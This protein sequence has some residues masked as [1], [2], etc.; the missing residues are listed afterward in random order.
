MGGKYV[1]LES[2][3]FLTWVSVG[4]SIQESCIGQGQLLGLATPRSIGNVARFGARVSWELILLK[5]Q[6]VKW[7]TGEVIGVAAIIWPLFIANR[8]KAAGGFSF[9]L[10]GGST[11]PE[12]LRG[13]A[14]FA[15]ACISFFPLFRFKTDVAVVRIRRADFAQTERRANG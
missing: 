14:C 4:T 9:D 3:I 13:L 8:V 1:I 10:T 7:I 15:C 12:F 2:C 6:Y 5:S 11:L